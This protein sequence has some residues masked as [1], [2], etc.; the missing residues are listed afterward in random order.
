MSMRMF[1]SSTAYGESIN[2]YDGLKLLA[3]LTMVIDHLGAYFWPHAEWPRAIGRMAFPLFLFLVGY[4]GKWK[5][6]GDL[7]IQAAAIILCGALT[8]HPV[9]SLNILV[10]IVFTRIVMSYL[11]R[12][13]I[14]PAFLLGVFVI[15]VAWWP[16]FIWCDYGTM[17]VLF[18]MSGYLKRRRPTSKETLLFL[19]A[20]IILHFFIE[21]W[22]FGF[23]G[24][25]VL[26]LLAVT[27]IVTF[28]T[29]D[30]QIRPLPNRLF[31]PFLCWMARNTLPLYTLHVMLFMAL[32][33]LLFP[34]RLLHF[35]WY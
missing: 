34:E 6:S 12:Y 2:S 22:S 21:W 9:F 33:R 16:L 25:S 24:G 29:K 23:H 30:F 27:A 15:A 26:I 8:F 32:E 13:N 7:V 17:A 35:A 1:K 14:T 3:L 19:Y 11:T 20:T 10:T 5:V 31:S 4:S 28:C 18:A